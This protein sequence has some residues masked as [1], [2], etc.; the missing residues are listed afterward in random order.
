LDTPLERKNDKGNRDD[1]AAGKHDDAGKIDPASVARQ[2]A[3]NVFY[4][5]PAAGDVNCRRVPGEEKYRVCRA[6]FVVPP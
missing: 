1:S 5:T 4:F 2:P 3:V 6:P